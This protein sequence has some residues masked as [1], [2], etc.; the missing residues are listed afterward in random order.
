MFL[1]AMFIASL[2]INLSVYTCATVN[3]LP[4][5]DWGLGTGD[6][7]LGIG[8]W[9]LGTGDS[10]KGRYFVFGHFLTISAAA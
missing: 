5:L 9:G 6:W 2:N 1:I 7:G 4:L 3:N 10:Y 8:D